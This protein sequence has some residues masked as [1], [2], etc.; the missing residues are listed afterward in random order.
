V[1]ATAHCLLVMEAVVEVEHI[2][3]LPSQFLVG[4]LILF[5]EVQEE[6]EVLTL[7]VRMEQ[8]PQFQARED[9]FQQIQ[10]RVEPGGEV[11]TEQ[12]VQAALTTE[13][14]GV[15]PPVMEQVEAEVQVMLLLQVQ[16]M[17]VMA[18]ILPR[19]QQALV[20]SPE[21]PVAHIGIV[22]EPEMPVLLLVEVAVAVTNFF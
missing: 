1:A 20:L 11:K 6:Q 5:R 21:V 18:V 17:V 4:K 3:Y 22:M 14:K 9:Q 10:V 16:V 2:M 15:A 13:V 7:M 8:Y 19:D 12:V